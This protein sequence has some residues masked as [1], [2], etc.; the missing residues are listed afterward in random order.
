[1]FPALSSHLLRPKTNHDVEKDDTIDHLLAKMIKLQ[2]ADGLEFLPPNFSRITSG[3]YQFGTKKIH[4]SVQQEQPVVRV[5][6]G[7][8]IFNRFVKKYGRIEC[9]KISKQPGLYFFFSSLLLSW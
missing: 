7:Y 5:G 6:G 8:M 9:L 4:I 2:L 1:M 3:V